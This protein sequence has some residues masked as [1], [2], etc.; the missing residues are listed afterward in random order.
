[1]PETYESLPFAE[2][3]DFLR[4]KLNVP[5]AHWDDLWRGMHSRGFMVA[6][7]MKEDM[8]K[9]F[10]EAVNKAIADGT[11][12][13][14]F[15][16]D[17]DTIVQKYGW[18]YNGTRGWR[19]ALI[20]NTNLGQA[21][22]AGRWKQMTDPEVLKLRPYL[23]YKHGDS[24]VPRPEHLAWNNLTLPADDP[25]WKT[26]APKNGWGCTCYVV[27]S[28]VRDLERMGKDGPDQAPPIEYY[29]WRDRNGVIHK[30]PVGIDPG[31]DYNPGQE[32]YNFIPGASGA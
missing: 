16:K 26:H 27:S 22:N 21:Y 4:L 7:A 31:F 13:A 10:H 8:V 11:T 5:T 6:G 20:F 24:I 18:T 19:S 15:R 9:D 17:F 1:M 23:T 14:D 2:A 25:W 3:I 32:A 28:S 12:L 30:V 29:D